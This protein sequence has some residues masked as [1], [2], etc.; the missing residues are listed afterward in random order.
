MTLPIPKQTQ[1]R[2]GV[3]REA[4]SDAELMVLFCQTLDKIEANSG[5]DASNALLRDFVGELLKMRLQECV[6]RG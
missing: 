6:S 4:L 5:L 3:E 2:L 1:P